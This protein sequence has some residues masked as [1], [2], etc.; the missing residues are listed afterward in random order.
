VGVCVSLCLVTGS[1]M[2][3]VTAAYWCF[4]V[5]GRDVA[6]GIVRDLQSLPPEDHV[7]ALADLECLALGRTVQDAHLMAKLSRRGALYW[8]LIPRSMRVWFRVEGILRYVAEDCARISAGQAPLERPL[9]QGRFELDTTT[10]AM[11]RR[12]S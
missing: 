1:V 5:W 2:L 11:G 12:G 4:K 3:S 6:L 8:Y 7:Q 9:R 10:I